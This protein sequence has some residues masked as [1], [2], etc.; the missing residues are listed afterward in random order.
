M[1]MNK[2]VMLF[3][4][5]LTGSVS[6]IFCQSSYYTHWYNFYNEEYIDFHTYGIVKLKE[7]YGPPNFGETPS[8]DKIEYHYVFILLEPI[9][10]KKELE[11][12]TVEEIQLIFP[13]GIKKEIE[14]GGG[15]IIEGRLF[16]AETGHH[17]TPVIL[18]VN[19]IAVNG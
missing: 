8:I 7:F 4:L 18:I 2:A 9:T 13:N 6:N 11:I 17:H 1:N 3:L 12:V 14:D 5:T 16:F 15:Y 19:R 10:F